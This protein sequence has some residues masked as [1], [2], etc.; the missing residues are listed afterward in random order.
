MPLVSKKP[1]V[2]G[3]VSGGYPAWTPPPLE[4]VE[5]TAP[6]KTAGWAPLAY[7]PSEYF[8]WFW[9][10]ISKWTEWFAG[11]SEDMFVVSSNPREGDYSTIALALAAAPA[12]GDTI[13]IK[14]DQSINIAAGGIVIPAGI[15]LRIKKGVV[16]NVTGAGAGGTIITFG[17]DCTI[18][19][20][21]VFN[22]TATGAI[23]A[24]VSLNGNGT[25]FENI[26]LNNNSTAVITD[27]FII[28][29][30]VAATYGE[31]ET[32]NTGGGSFT[33]VLTDAS[34]FLN[35]L[36]RVREI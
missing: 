13:L 10:L 29:P 30:A 32:T 25:V 17:A 28:Q 1:T 23:A 18:E 31:G 11:Q 36:V 6:E 3:G 20:D 35:N 19:G 12:S 4:T 22:I 16:F 2:T 14:S 8:N 27:G 24:G 21:L 7:P 15:K 26:V 9:Y 34:G 5:P 33:N